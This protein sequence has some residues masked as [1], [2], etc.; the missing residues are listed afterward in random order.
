MTDMAA[1]HVTEN[2]NLVAII[3]GDIRNTLLQ[4]GELII[5]TRCDHRIIETVRRQTGD[6]KAI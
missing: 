5:G 6:V 2:R 1:A 4:R 3:D